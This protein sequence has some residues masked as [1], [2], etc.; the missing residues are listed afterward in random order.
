[1]AKSIG[2]LTLPQGSLVTRTSQLENDSR[3]SSVYEYVLTNTSLSSS[4]TLNISNIPSNSIITKVEMY[5]VDPFVDSYGNPVSISIE[6][7][8]STLMDGKW[9]DPCEIGLYSTDCYYI[10]KGTTNELNIN[11]NAGNCIE[12]TVIIRFVT[13]QTPTSYEAFATVDDMD[14][15]SADRSLINVVA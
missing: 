10:V 2:S 3:F 1:M 7:G 11:H 14:F 13:Y 4:V 6:G 9:N 15:A 8:E 12:G 5:V